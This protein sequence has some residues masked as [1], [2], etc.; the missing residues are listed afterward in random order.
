[1]KKKRNKLNIINECYIDDI[2]ALSGLHYQSFQYTQRW[3]KN[4]K[5]LCSVFKN[6]IWNYCVF[7]WNLPQFEFK[8]IKSHT[9]K[10][11]ETKWKFNKF[12]YEAKT[13]WKWISSSKI[14][15]FYFFWTKMDKKKTSSQNTH[16]Q[17]L[18]FISNV[19]HAH[20]PMQL[21]KMYF[22]T[23]QIKKRHFL[24][25]LFNTSLDPNKLRKTNKK[26]KSTGNIERKKNKLCFF[27]HFLAY[28]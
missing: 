7:D 17:I 22:E 3:K 26:W 6:K 28:T 27:L 4:R 8:V 25:N 24:A 11:A 14:W 21:K 20:R 18:F 15:I 9:K 2:L 16:E 10:E 13:K 19:S 5:S 23:K 1:M 12:I